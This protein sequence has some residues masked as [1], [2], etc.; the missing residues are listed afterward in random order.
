MN[1][2]ASERALVRRFNC[3]ILELD[4]RPAPD[5][6]FDFAIAPGLHSVVLR[7]RAWV[8]TF[9][10]GPFTPPTQRLEFRASAGERIHIC[11]GLRDASPGYEWTPYVVT[12][13]ADESPAAALL[14]AID[15][16]GG[17]TSPR[18]TLPYSWTHR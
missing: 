15:R 4:S 1:L 2:P 5:L 13:G 6:A 18:R 7:P 9:P 11:M 12:T 8:S 16:Q 3:D 14:E 17:C 10:L